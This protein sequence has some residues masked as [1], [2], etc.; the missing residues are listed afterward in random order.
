MSCYENI[1]AQQETYIQKQKIVHVLSGSSLILN[2]SLKDEPTKAKIDIL[3]FE[4]VKCNLKTSVPGDLEYETFCERQ[5]QA[6]RR[7]LQGN[8]KYIFDKQDIQPYLDKVYGIKIKPT[9]PKDVA[10]PAGRVR[11]I[12]ETDASARWDVVPVEM[13]PKVGKSDRILRKRVLKLNYGT[14]K[15]LMKTVW[16]SEPVM[17]G[18][19]LPR[20]NLSSSTGHLPIKPASQSPQIQ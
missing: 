7:M 16:C 18:L 3:T 6:R 5:N 13:V 10:K 20:T 9:E 12:V 8:L 4:I 14:R 15:T 1:Y 2:S 19:S 17:R 11:E